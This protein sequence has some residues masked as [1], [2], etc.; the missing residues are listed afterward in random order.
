VR[1]K[2]ELLKRSIMFR[3]KRDEDDGVRRPPERGY[4]WDRWRKPTITG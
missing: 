2:R 4:D 3:K 1:G